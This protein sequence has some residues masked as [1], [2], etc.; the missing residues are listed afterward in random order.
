VVIKKGQR[1]W[2]G[3]SW[4]V[5]FTPCRAGK[6]LAVLTCYCLAFFVSGPRPHKT[7]SNAWPPCR[8]WLG[9]LLRFVAGRAGAFYWHRFWCFLRLGFVAVPI[10]L[11]QFRFVLGNLRRYRR[12]AQ[13]RFAW[14]SL[15][16]VPCGLQWS[17]LGVAGPCILWQRFVG[18]FLKTHTECGQHNKSFKATA[19]RASP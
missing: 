1:F 4:Q 16:F 13:I 8:S 18:Q 5:R 17:L 12:L 15:S 6:G 10:Q 9:T 2:G 11:G 3:R 14:Q 19:L 7:H